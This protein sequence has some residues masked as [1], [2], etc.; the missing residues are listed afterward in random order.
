MFGAIASPLLSSGTGTGHSRTLKQRLIKS[1]SLTLWLV[2]VPVEQ[3]GLPPIV[4]PEFTQSLQPNPEYPY[5]C[6]P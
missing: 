3:G 1:F 5:I 6:S 4:N 2:A